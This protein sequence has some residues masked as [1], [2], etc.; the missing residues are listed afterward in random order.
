MRMMLVTVLWLVKGSFVMPYYEFAQQ[1]PRRTKFLLYAI[2]AIL[3]TTYIGLWIAT[4]LEMKMSL[5]F[6]GY[7]V[8]CSIRFDIRLTDLREQIQPSGWSQ[9]RSV[10]PAKHL[11]HMGCL[12]RGVDWKTLPSAYI[13]C[14][15]V[16]GYFAQRGY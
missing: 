9:S 16:C 15:R 13:S 7:V 4:S 3:L 6:E 10:H 8:V 2:T 14:C 11:E 12:R 5:E 1:L